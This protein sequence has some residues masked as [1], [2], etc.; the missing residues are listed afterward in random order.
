MKIYSINEI[1]QATNSFLNPKTLNTTSTK[2]LTK[3]IILPHK[4]IVQSKKSI[5]KINFTQEKN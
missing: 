2:S 1:V 3:K 5:N 4:N